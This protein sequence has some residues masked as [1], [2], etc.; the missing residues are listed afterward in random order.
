MDEL[1]TRRS[2]ASLKA[3][4]KAFE[5]NDNAVALEEKVVAEMP[6]HSNDQHV[7]ALARVTGARVAFALDGTS[8]PGLIADFKD[9]SFSDRPRGKMCHRV[10]HASLLEHCASCPASARKM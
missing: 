5:A 10:D 7:L 6:Y 8:R 3:A 1:A 4:S 9:K 2:L